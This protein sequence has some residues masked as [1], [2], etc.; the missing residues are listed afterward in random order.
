ML[1]ARTGM[2]WARPAAAAAKDAKTDA[3]LR[4]GVIIVP[5]ILCRWRIVRLRGPEGLTWVAEKRLTC[6]T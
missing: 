4:H 5:H 2:S 3:A 6:V 1:T